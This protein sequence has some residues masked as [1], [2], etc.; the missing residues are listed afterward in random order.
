MLKFS[1]QNELNSMILSVPFPAL[2]QWGA[3]KGP[4]NNG[5]YPPQWL[6]K[7]Q[8]GEEGVDDMVFK[9]LCTTMAS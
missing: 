6:H 4:Q 7:R 5:V 2:L 1:C 8:L 3:E 9:I